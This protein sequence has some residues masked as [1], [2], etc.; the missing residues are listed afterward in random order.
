MNAC[1]LSGVRFSRHSPFTSTPAMKS[2]SRSLALLLGG[3][4]LLALPLSAAPL[5]ADD[6][7]FMTIYEQVQKALVNE[8]LNAVKDA[9]HALPDEAGADIL[10]A[11]DLK[12]ARD[13]FATLSVTAEKKVAGN[14]D[15]HV[16]NCP[17]AKKDWVQKSTTLANPYMGKEMLDC[18][19]E[20]K[21][22]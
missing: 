11:G 19:V 4:S 3:C 18:G 12:A 20:K 17:M 7:K 1:A 2:I 22:K 21:Q 15:Y 8:N 14:S 16:F 6:E 5:S 13:A 10:K 9:A